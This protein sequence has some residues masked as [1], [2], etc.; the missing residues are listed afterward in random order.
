MEG[1][2]CLKMS[3]QW[4]L[5]KRS[6]PPKTS[7]CARFWRGVGGS[8]RLE[9]NQKRNKYLKSSGHTLYS[10]PIVLYPL[11]VFSVVFAVLS[12]SC[13]GFF[14]LLCG[15]VERGMAMRW[16]CLLACRLSFDVVG[17]GEGW[18]RVGGGG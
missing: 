15:D 10:P 4:L 7:H 9:C 18:W 11:C 1:P 5:G 13:D 14:T 2:T 12:A 16:A 6:Y 17:R 8:G 3:V